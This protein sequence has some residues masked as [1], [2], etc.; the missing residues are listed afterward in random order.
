MDKSVWE[1]AVRKDAD[2]E[3]VGSH[4]RCKRGVCSEEGKGVPIVKRRE[5][6][7]E[8]V[9]EGTVEKGIHS[10][11]Q[12][13]TNGAGILCRKERWEEENGTELQIFE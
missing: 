12:V 11:I 10:A 7:G 8:G 6:G 1:E 13:T 4:D 2:E 5:R 9:H 3:G